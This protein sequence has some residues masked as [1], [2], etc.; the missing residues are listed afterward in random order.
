MRSLNRKG[1]LIVI[2]LLGFFGYII[3]GVFGSAY[4]SLERAAFFYLLGGYIHKNEVLKQVKQ[5][6]IQLIVFTFAAWG[7][8]TVFYYIMNICMISNGVKYQ[9]LYL[10]CEILLRAISV[11][12]CSVCI[13]L[14]FLGMHFTNAIVNKIAA[15]T[16]GVYLIHEGLF[17]RWWLWKGLLKVDTVQYASPMFI[18]WAIGSIVLVFVV[19]SVIDLVRISFLEEP[20]LSFADRII[21]IFHRKFAAVTM[22]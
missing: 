8:G 16:F 9:I 18:F 4:G 22:K 6:R 5:K 3:D 12:V 1:Q 17:A 11:T 19:C 15:T 20:A 10:L 21:T 7:L 13:F 14:L 2:L